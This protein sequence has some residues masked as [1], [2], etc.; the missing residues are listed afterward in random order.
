[1]SHKTLIFG[2]VSILATNRNQIDFGN[3]YQVYWR[4]K[5]QSSIPDATQ[6]RSILDV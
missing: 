5:N 6:I 1:M 4:T 3:T 2:Y